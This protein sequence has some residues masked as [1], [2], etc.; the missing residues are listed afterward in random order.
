MA[1]RYKTNRTSDDYSVSVQM[2]SI[3]LGE[4]HLTRSK[5]GKK[6]HTPIE[7]YIL[8]NRFYQ[9]K[10]GLKTTTKKSGSALLAFPTENVYSRENY[11]LDNLLD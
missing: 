2:H 4:A 10:H 9:D 3:A 5:L 7:N 6:P 8:I 1:K 11:L